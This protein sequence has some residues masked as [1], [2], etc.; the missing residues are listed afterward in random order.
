MMQ[1]TTIKVRIV[2]TASMVFT[3]AKIFANQHKSDMSYENHFMGDSPPQKVVTVGDSGVGKTSLLC[4]ID[5]RFNGD[6]L[7][8]T[9]PEA[10]FFTGET[11]SGKQVQLNIWDTAG[12]DRF[13]SLTSLY[14]RGAVG[15]IFMFDVARFETFKS[16]DRWYERVTETE[17][18]KVIVLIGN[19]CDLQRDVPVNTAD[20]WARAHNARYIETSVV[21][22][23][24]CDLVIPALAEGLG[25]LQ[26]EQEETVSLSGSSKK[27]K[28]KKHLCLLI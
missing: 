5:N 22:S 28:K 13:E 10:F 7:P 9:A 17:V 26:V 20:Q 8:T 4:K 1:T 16:L 21:E 6:I 14:F 19:K 15:V 12:Q 25:D 11:E 18:P 3:V 27:K 23:I 24:G 2:S